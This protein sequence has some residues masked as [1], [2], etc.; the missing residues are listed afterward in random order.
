MKLIVDTCSWLKV[1]KLDNEKIIRLKNLLYE[2]DLW[3]TH[4]LQTE[5]RYYLS[6]YLDFKNFSIQ[7]VSIQKLSAFTEKELDLADLSIIQF[8]RQN[9]NCIVISDDGAALNVLDIFKIKC[10]QISEFIF[11]LVKNDLLKKNQAIR[12]VKKLRTWKNIRE[13]KKK[14]LIS[15]IIGLT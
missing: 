15:K 10:F 3:L 9:P 7:K 4:E 2:A 12:S 14:K 8:G 6:D 1:Q 5:L 13:K 11:F